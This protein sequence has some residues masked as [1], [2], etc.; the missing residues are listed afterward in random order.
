[1]LPSS[2][3]VREPHYTIL[4]LI[5]WHFSYFSTIFSKKDKQEKAFSELPLDD[6]KEQPDAPSGRENSDLDQ[7]KFCAVF[8]RGC[9]LG[10]F[11]HW[12]PSTFF[13]RLSRLQCGCPKEIF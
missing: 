8:D 7:I 5:N 9:R 4:R 10:A 13:L 1:M 3:D 12:K 11:H 2:I 6:L